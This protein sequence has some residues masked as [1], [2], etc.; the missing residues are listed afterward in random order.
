MP[1]EEDQSTQTS[2]TESTDELGTGIIEHLAVIRTK[3]ERLENAYEETKEALEKSN[4]RI[5]AKGREEDVRKGLMEEAGVSEVELEL[6]LGG[7]RYGEKD[8]FRHL[9]ILNQRGQM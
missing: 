6:E 2:A 3:F 4:E 1:P 9:N 7:L 8:Y 5:E